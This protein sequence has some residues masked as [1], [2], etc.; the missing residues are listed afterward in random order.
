MSCVFKLMDTL[1][2]ILEPYAVTEFLHKK[3]HLFQEQIQEY[4]EKPIAQFLSNFLKEG[5]LRSGNRKLLPILCCFQSGLFAPVL[6]ELYDILRKNSLESQPQKDKDRY[7]IVVEIKENEMITVSHKRKEESRKTDPKESFQFEWKLK[8][9]FDKRIETITKVD[10]KIVDWS[11]NHSTSPEIQK[12]FLSTIKNYLPPHLMF[13]KSWEKPAQ[14]LNWPDELPKLIQIVD[15]FDI[16]GI[17]VYKSKHYRHRTVLTEAVINFISTLTRL[18]EG[19][20]VADKVEAKLTE[21]FSQNYSFSECI[22]KYFYLQKT[23]ENNDI[24][25]PTMKILKSLL[26]HVVKPF[27]MDLHTNLKEYPFQL[28]EGSRKVHIN[29]K[30]NGALVVHRCIEQSASQEPSNFFTF[31]WEVKFGLEGTAFSK[32]EVLGMEII[33]LSFHEQT[34]KKIKYELQSIFANIIQS[35]SAFQS[36]VTSVSVSQLLQAVLQTLH[37]SDKELIIQ[38]TKFEN[39][40]VVTLLECLDRTLNLCPNLPSVFVPSKKS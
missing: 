24:E 19:Q 28:Q 25:T 1:S 36:P 39:V 8:L 35:A 18:A 20:E 33:T 37:A 30:R 12:L 10:F 14:L 26:P 9:E 6:T 2:K 38:N 5:V 4:T 21:N 31:E 27:L 15:I 29:F 34:A 23:K 32:L 13:T 7:S 16:D 17:P 22:E 40:N 3:F 11:F